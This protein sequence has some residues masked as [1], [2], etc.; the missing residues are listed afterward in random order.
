MKAGSIAAFLTL[1][2]EVLKIFDEGM[3]PPSAF[4]EVGED[5]LLT[6]VTVLH[7]LLHKH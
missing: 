4:P 1:K 5:T 3:A 6:R 7:R 2:K